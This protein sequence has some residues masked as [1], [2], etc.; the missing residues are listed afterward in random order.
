MGAAKVARDGKRNYF[1]HC[2]LRMKVY[3]ES[4]LTLHSQAAANVCVEQL[5]HCWRTLTHNFCKCM[6]VRVKH[7]FFAL[8]SISIFFFYFASFSLSSD[9]PVLLVP[10]KS[11]KWQA[12]ARSHSQ[13]RGA[14]THTHLHT[15]THILRHFGDVLWAKKKY[16][17]SKQSRKKKKRIL[18]RK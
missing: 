7:F 14:L 10:S 5:G 1:D 12:K 15:G 11:S 9:C 3:Y 13:K 18:H 6:R 8:H 17:E 4:K 2:G 16:S